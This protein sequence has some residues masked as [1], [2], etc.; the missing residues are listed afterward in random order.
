MRRVEVSRTI[1]QPA[2]RVWELLVD[3]RRWPDWGS[4]VRS[5]TVDGPTDRIGPG[6]SGRVTTV[7]GVDLPYRVT[8]W[9]ETAARRSW[10]WHVA[11]VPATGHTVEP[12]DDRRCTLT[13]D[14]PWYA[15]AYAI[16]LRRALGN[17]ERELRRR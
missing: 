16:V 1:D 2:D 11:G 7:L 3:T 9:S 6:A 12:L 17:V 4:T 15:G 13:M 5:A 14:V 10:R 8:D